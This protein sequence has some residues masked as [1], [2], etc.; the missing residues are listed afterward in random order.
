MC[1][2]DSNN[3]CPLLH[4]ALGD[5]NHSCFHA[6]FDEADLYESDTQPVFY[7]NPITRTKM[8]LNSAELT[9]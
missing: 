4:D 3:T 9:S 2:T 6:N 7:Y 8:T 1:I 5:S